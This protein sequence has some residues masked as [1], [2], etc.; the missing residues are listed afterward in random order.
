MARKKHNKPLSPVTGMPSGLQIA[1]AKAPPTPLKQDWTA[2]AIFGIFFLFLFL[3]CSPALDSK[4]SLPKLM[5]LGAGVLALGVLLIARLW[6]NHGVAP[7]RLVLLLAL[8]LGAWWIASTP[9][10][11]HL[12]TALDGEYDYY[13]GLWA[14][15]CWLV[16]FAAAMFIPADTRAVRNITLLLVAAVVP[17]AAINILETTGIT[18]IGLNEVSTLGDRVAAGAL[19][20]FAIPFTVIALIRARHWAARTGLA[21][22]LALFLVSEFFSQ[23]RGPWL[24]LAVAIF[25]LAAGLA[26][27]KA[28]WKILAALLVA[29]VILGGLTAKLNPMVAQRFATLAHASQDESLNQ[30][31]V[32]YRA[33]VRAVREHPVTGIGFENFRNS[34]PSYR[35]ADDIWFFNNIIPTMVHNGYLETA[36]NNGIPA[37]LLYLALLATVLA[38]LGKQSFRESDRDKRDLLLGL[39]AALSAYLV[40]D[41]TGWLDMALA[42]AFWIM[43]GFAVNQTSQSAPRPSLQSAKPVILAFSVP[44]LVL[45]LYLLNQGYARIIADASLFKAQSLDVKTQWRETE[46]LVRQALLSLPEDSR[47]LMVV[48]Q[49]YGN[50]FMASH[51]PEDYARSHELLEASYRRNPFDRMRLVNILALE[52]AA[53]E[54]GQITAPSAFAQKALETLSETDGDNPGFHELKSLFFAAQGRF[55]EALAA[56]REAR[57]LA[58]MEERFRSAEAEYQKSLSAKQD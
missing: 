53:L 48:G 14:H 29:I 7:S 39:L 2:Q 18:K 3:A 4:F 5:V 52:R 26:R 41:M 21:G 44:M 36:L 37:L 40:Q 46:A 1:P 51:E 19:M 49:I 45:S 47:T 22:L 17:V 23:G 33:A 54:L 20:N 35:G 42:P 57:R 27:S 56:I 11:L 43:L 31:L 12:P 50:R 24:G 15:L 58:P 13:N 30:R 10:A 38:R 16:L 8:G 32:Y 34:Y 9:F 6:R 55:N 28:H 25:I